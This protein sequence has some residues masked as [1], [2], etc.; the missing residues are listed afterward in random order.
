[1][2]LNRNVL[3]DF[4]EIYLYVVDESYYIQEAVHNVLGDSHDR[5]RIGYKIGCTTPVM[6]KNIGNGSLYVLEMIKLLI[7]KK[8]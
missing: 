5:H 6:Q 8:D 7:L 3:L 4:D 1:M 2:E